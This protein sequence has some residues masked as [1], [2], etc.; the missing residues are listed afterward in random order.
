MNNNQITIARADDHTLFR[1]GLCT[2]I[3][4]FPRY[5]VLFDVSNGKEF[6][7]KIAQFGPPQ[8]A[9]LDISMPEM[10]GF[11]T[12]ALL[13]EN[14]PEVKILALTTMDA[15]SCIIKM[16]KHGA[17]G[18]VMKYA[19]PDELK[20]AFEEVMSIGYYYNDII[21]RKVMNAIHLIDGNP[22]EAATL[23]KTTPREME[24]LQLACSEKNYHRIAEEMFVSER[25]VDGYRDSLFKKFNVSSR[26]GLILYAIKNSLVTI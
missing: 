7:E 10:D 16:I 13:K 18:Y 9:L 26:V 4:L 17:R 6:I 19:D 12:A 11:Q 2:L 23:A 25:T 3:E 5:K 15:E 14:Y 20:L 22:D 24:F 8:I 21:T 1:K